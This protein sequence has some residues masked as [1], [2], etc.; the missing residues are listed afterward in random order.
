MR[1]RGFELIKSLSGVAPLL[2]LWAA[3]ASAQPLPSVT[4]TSQSGGDWSYTGTYSP[5]RWGELSG[6]GLCSTGQ[7][8]TPIPL[9][10]LSSLPLDLAPPSFHYGSTA[11]RMVNTGST[12]EFTYAPGSFIRSLGTDYRLAQFHFHT[13]SEHTLD[14]VSYPLEL[15]LVHVDSTGAPAVVV[16]L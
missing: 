2:A 4:T 13:P 7:Q 11:L 6:Y 10:S 9:W 3:T 1:T 15:H 8:Q 14:M 12:V 16:G 5:E